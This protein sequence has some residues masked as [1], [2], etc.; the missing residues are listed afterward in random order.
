[1]RILKG[2]HDTIQWNATCHCQ[3]SCWDPSLSWQAKE[4][5]GLVDAA[6][7]H[8]HIYTNSAQS[9]MAI[10]TMVDESM[11]R[12]YCIKTFLQKI[13]FFFHSAILRPARMVSWQW[14][15]GWLERT[16]SCNW[17]WFPWMASDFVTKET[18]PKFGRS[19]AEFCLW[20][21]GFG[22]MFYVVLFF[23][24]KLLF[25]CSQVPSP[26][27]WWI[28]IAVGQE[29]QQSLPKWDSTSGNPNNQLRLI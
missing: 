9:E 12:F 14:P 6:M 22:M 29:H 25:D 19:S 10:K 20:V 21:F 17:P 28:W 8:Q 11:K 23:G 7:G 16:C 15:S 27:I 26:E 13:A 18:A 24:C 3:V 5:N 2:C 1:M 4:K